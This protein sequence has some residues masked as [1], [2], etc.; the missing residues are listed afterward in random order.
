[1]GVST[2]DPRLQTGA[3]ITDGTDLYEVLGIQRGPGPMGIRTVRVLVENCRN[4]RGLEFVP[5]KVRATF[6]L[7]RHP[8]APACPD[9]I[10]D[11]GW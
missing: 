9:L 5:E 6:N 1:M 8:P 2:P 3:Y 11:I 10:D 7:V 4:L